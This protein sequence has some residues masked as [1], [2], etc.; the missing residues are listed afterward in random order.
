MCAVAY[1][2]HRP[3]SQAPK[4]RA[5]NARDHLRLGEATVEPCPSFS[6]SAPILTTALN[7]LSSSKIGWLRNS[8]SPEVKTDLLSRASVLECGGGS[9]RTTPLFEDAKNGTVTP[10]RLTRFTPPSKPK[11]K[12]HQ[13]PRRPRG[14]TPSHPRHWSVNISAGHRLIEIKHYQINID[15][16]YKT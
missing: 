7:D 6:N 5:M 10:Y 9:L 16:R 12:S 4:E 15:P 11:Q 14:L 13:H 3:I 1:I 2:R 8:H